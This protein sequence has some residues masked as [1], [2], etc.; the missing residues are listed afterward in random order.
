MENQLRISIQTSG[1]YHQYVAEHGI[2]ATVKF[3]KDCGF[4]AFDYS[5]CETLP[6]TLLYKKELN[7]YYNQTV[8]QIIELHKPLKKALDDNGITIPLMHAPFPTYVLD[9][10]NIND[11]LVMAI[12]KC[13]AVAEFLECPALVVHPY[14]NKD[15]E[16]QHKVNIDMYSKLIPAA[17]KHGVTICLE[18]MWSRNEKGDPI[19]AGCSTVEETC[20][21]IDK[22][23]E[24]AGEKVFGYCLDV[25]HA[26][27]LSRDIYE[28][29][30]VLGDRLVTLHLH[31]NNV[32]DDL[33]LAPFMNMGFYKTMNWDLVCKG[34]KDVGYK[35][36]I[37]FECDC[38]TKNMPKE[39]YGPALQFV[40]ATGRYFRDKIING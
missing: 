32:H 26:N 22:L 5:M 34:L 20:F 1:S 15:L 10:D 16:F 12:Q 7:E 13:C 9:Y 38:V 35:G 25:G 33:H 14:T 17:K 21:Y 3:A 27:M 19:D 8:E 11:H 40:S 39:L 2:E 23:N 4:E 24:I 28:F 18:N 6:P 36:A 31:D 30:T 29:I 37:N